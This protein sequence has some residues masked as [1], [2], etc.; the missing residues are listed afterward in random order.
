[1]SEL[2][3]RGLAFDIVPYEI[4]KAENW[5]LLYRLLAVYGAEVGPVPLVFVGDVAVVYDTF[6]GLGPQPQKYAG[7]AYQLALE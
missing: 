7:L 3:A 5:Q 6:Y 2:Q 1:M 4:H